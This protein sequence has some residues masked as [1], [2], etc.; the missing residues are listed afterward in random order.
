MP[1]SDVLVLAGGAPLAH[2][3]SLARVMLDGM[4]NWYFL[5]APLAPLETRTALPAPG[6]GDESSAAF[7]F[8]RVADGSP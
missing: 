7:V 6:N 4:S 2:T 1:R 5:A 3:M 8:A